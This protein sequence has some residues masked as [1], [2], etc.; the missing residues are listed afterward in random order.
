MTDLTAGDIKSALEAAQSL[1]GALDDIYKG[2][3]TLSDGET[4]ADDV[5]TGVAI[6]DPAAAPWIALGKVMVALTVVAVQ[7]GWIKPDPNP[8]SDAQLSMG[9]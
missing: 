9:R 2:T 3:A 6:I 8:E 7:N 4:I 5:L 1:M